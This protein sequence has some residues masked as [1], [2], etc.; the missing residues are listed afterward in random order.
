MTRTVEPLLTENPNRFVIYPIQHADIWNS[1]KKQEAS[2]WTAE[3]IDL[4]QDLVDWQNLSK[5]EQYFIKHVLALENHIYHPAGL[6]DIGKYMF[7][8]NRLEEFARAEFLLLSGAPV[9]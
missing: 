7:S 6:R 3:E 5:D 2:F 4:N 9:Q 1:F 8:R